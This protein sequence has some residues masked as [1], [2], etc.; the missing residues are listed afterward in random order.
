LDR[1]ECI[2][3]P[4]AFESFFF[5]FLFLCSNMFA[6]SVYRQPPITEVGKQ[7]KDNKNSDNFIYKV[8]ISIISKILMGYWV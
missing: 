1:F 5:S 4:A 2:N 7:G 6:L 3:I 8:H